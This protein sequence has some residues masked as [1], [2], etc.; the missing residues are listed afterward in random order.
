MTLYT[1]EI[2]SSSGS[3]SELVCTYDSLGEITNIL[4]RAEP[5]RVFEYRISSS[6]GCTYSAKLFPFLCEKLVTE[7]DWNKEYVPPKFQFVDKV[8]T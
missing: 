6:G 5:Y 7:F 8:D 4:D 3:L 2:R 1:I